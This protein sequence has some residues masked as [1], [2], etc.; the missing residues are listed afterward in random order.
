[1]SINHLKVQILE[2]IGSLDQIQSEKVLGFIRQV[3][4]SRES[5]EDYVNFKQRAMEE[6]QR[7]LDGSRD[8]QTA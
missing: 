5:S 1:M 6:I 8:P 7:A 3:L 4:R 2:S